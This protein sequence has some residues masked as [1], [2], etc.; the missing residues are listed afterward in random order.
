[1]LGLIGAKSQSNPTIFGTGERYITSLGNSAPILGTS[2]YITT[3]ELN[4]TWFQGRGFWTEPKTWY[5]VNVLNAGVD[6]CQHEFLSSDPY[7]YARGF[8]GGI[9]IACAVMHAP[10]VRCSW[11]IETR[12]SICKKCLMHIVE[13][14][15]N[16]NPPKPVEPPKPTETYETLL[17]KLNKYDK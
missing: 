11:T 9:G 4:P 1:M 13:T 5:V 16:P 14:D 17:E 10:G 2:S 8:G 6:T 12:K 3:T 7:S 15:E